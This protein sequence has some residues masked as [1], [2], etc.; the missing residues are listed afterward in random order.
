MSINNGTTNVAPELQVRL[1]IVEQA[2]LNYQKV[3]GDVDILRIKE[4]PHVILVFLPQAVYCDTCH[5]FSAG[6]VCQY[7]AGTS[8]SEVNTDAG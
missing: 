8:A 1:E 7:C 3:G 6:T 2:L 5:H 4:S